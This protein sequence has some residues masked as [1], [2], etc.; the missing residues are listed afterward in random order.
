MFYWRSLVP[1]PGGLTTLTTLGYGDV[2]P[3]TSYARSFAILEAI[4]GVIYLAIIISRLV[5][6]YIANSTKNDLS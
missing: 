4:I 2:I 1:K 6:L 3:V 5:G